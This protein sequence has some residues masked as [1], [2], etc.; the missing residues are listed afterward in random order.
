MLSQQ[1]FRG[2]HAQVYTPKQLN[3]EQ[4]SNPQ[5]WLE[6]GEDEQRRSFYRIP[7]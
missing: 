7:D 2:H 6:A 5:I 1:K 3:P 4:F